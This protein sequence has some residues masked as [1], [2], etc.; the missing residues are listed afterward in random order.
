MLLG[1][2]IY[3]SIN[4]DIAFPTVIFKKLLG[5]DGTFEVSKKH[6]FDIFCSV[7]KYLFGNLVPWENICFV[8]WYRGKLFLFQFDT[9][10][11]YMFWYLIPWENSF[12][13]WYSGKIFRLKCDTVRKYMFC[14]L[15]PWEIISLSIWYRG[16]T[17]V[18]KSY[19]VGIFVLC[20][21]LHINRTW[22]S[23]IPTFTAVWL[24]Y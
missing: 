13:N 10:G 12:N 2:A 7:V 4:L 23:V 9:V 11:K 1:L 5:N 17:F 15:I 22:S 18:L 24:K 8:I 21:D 14:N 6:I 20:S 16:K 19:T 3:N